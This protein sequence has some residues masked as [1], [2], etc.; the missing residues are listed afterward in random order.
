MAIEEQ[1]ATSLAL[2]VSFR[3]ESVCG[4]NL[5]RRIIIERLHTGLARP[6]PIEDILTRKATDLPAHDVYVVGFPSQPFANGK[7]LRST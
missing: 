3:L 6:P 5:N 4:I 1:H 2:V 7:E